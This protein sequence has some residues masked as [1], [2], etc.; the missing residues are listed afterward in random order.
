MQSTWCRCITAAKERHACHLLTFLRYAQC[1]GLCFGKVRVMTAAT[2]STRIMTGGRIAKVESWLR[3]N[4]KSDWKFKLED[5]SD[6]MSRKTYVLFFNDK[7]DYDLFRLRF[8]PVRAVNRNK[9]PDKE[10]SANTDAAA[11]S[12]PAVV[13]PAP[14]PGPPAVKPDLG[15]YLKDTANSFVSSMAQAFASKPAPNEG[16]DKDE[17][18]LPASFRS[19]G[20]KSTSSSTVS[21][22][23]PEAPKPSTPAA[24]SQSDGPTNIVID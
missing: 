7:M 15:A 18:S 23:K 16:A 9:A 10:T 17:S 19:G 2:Y 22:P 4:A 3:E 6:D 5:V 8:P 20:A 11:P 1:G 24:T 13:Q 21:R 12:A 14:D